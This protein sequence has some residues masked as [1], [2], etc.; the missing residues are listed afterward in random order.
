[1]AP[2]KQPVSPSMLK[3]EGTAVIFN[4][5]E[6]AAKAFWL[7]QNQPGNV[8]VRYGARKARYAEMLGPTSYIM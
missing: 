3:F 5:E 7:D 4:S 2:G 8:V 6:E 1:M